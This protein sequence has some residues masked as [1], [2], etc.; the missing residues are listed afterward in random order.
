MPSNFPPIRCD[1]SAGALIARIGV[2]ADAQDLPGFK[3]VGQ[4]QPLGLG[5]YACPY[6][7]FGE[8]GVA[9]FAHVGGFEA[10]SRVP[11]RPRPIRQVPEALLSQSRGCAICESRM[12]AKGDC[13][14]VPAR[15]ASAK[16]PSRCTSVAA[17]HG[18]LRNGRPLIQG[19]YRQS[20]AAAAARLQMGA[21]Q[22]V[23]DEQGYR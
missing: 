10:M 17:R 19:R 23:R 16:P 13:T 5:V 21:A 3:R 2:K 18:A 20:E 1:G 15:R 4:Q 11:L 6:R 8:P 14:A 7:G 12:I 22:G 9:D